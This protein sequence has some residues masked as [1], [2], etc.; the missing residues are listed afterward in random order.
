MKHQQQQEHEQ[1]K[2][3]LLL[4]LLCENLLRS[5]CSCKFLHGKII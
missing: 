4:L 2:Q 3:L 5:S 1:E